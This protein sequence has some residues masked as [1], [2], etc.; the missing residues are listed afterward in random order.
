MAKEKVKEKY[1]LSYSAFFPI[2]SEPENSHP[3]YDA[4]VDLGAA[5]K[6]YLTINYAE[7]KAY[8]DDSL[9]LDLKEFAGGQLD[10]ETLLNELEVEAALFGSKMEGDAL[11]DS[12]DDR[13]KSGGYAYIQKLATKTGTVHRACFLYKVT[14][15]MTSDN[16]DTKAEGFTFAHNAVSYSVAADNAGAWRVR[17]DCDTEADAKAFIAQT[18]GQNA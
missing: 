11:T 5:V 16:A 17:K 14:P 1:G 15:K 8:G 10:A 18:A 2:K 12:K 13:C 7:S 3:T 6:A 4:A 9:Q